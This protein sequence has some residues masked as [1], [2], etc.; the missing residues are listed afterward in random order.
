MIR[1]EMNSDRKAAIV[2]GV[3]FI[4]AT[5]AIL[6]STGFTNKHYLTFGAVGMAATNLL[7]YNINLLNF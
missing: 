6:L 3:L 5:A 2:V 1:K 4:T 7:G